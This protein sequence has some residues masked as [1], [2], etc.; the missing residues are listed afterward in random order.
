MSHDPR[1]YAAALRDAV[2]STLP[3]S[4]RPHL[5]DLREMTQPQKVKAAFRQRVIDLVRGKQPRPSRRPP[6]ATPTDT[7]TPTP[8]PP[9]LP[10]VI[11]SMGKKE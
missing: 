9:K 7:P 3:P 8:T 10:P 1:R 6:A 4:L 5:D 11:A 2:P